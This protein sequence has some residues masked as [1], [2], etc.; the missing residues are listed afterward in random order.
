MSG[1][2]MGVWLALLL[3]LAGPASGADLS[4]LDWTQRPGAPLPLDAKLVD[5]AGRPTTLRE[6]AGGLPLVLAPGYFHCPNLC[7]V[8][9][10]D[11]LSALARSGLVAGQ[12]YALALVTIDPAE[13]PADAAAARRDGVERHPAPGA[14]SGWRYLT[15]PA[16]SLAAVQDAAGF[17][18]RFDPALRQF[19]HPAGVVLASPGG[20][21]SGYLLGVG[22]APAD[23][24]A[25]IAAARDG[26]VR[27]ANPVLLLCF[28]YDA[29]TGRYTLAVTQALRLAAA[30]TVLGIAGG[31]AWLHRGRIRA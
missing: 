26:L 23:L 13:T 12:D 31:L 27:S 1:R 4:G 14:E 25:A 19:L 6:V 5:E 30:A 21:V 15:G 11:L 10:E 24:A 18:A 16:A 7:G 3:L 22:Y 28:T 20:L 17:R 29:A 8:V 9:R 2:A